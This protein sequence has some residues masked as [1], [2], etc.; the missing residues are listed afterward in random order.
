MGLLNWLFG[1]R[2]ATGS[3]SADARAKNVATAV[4][5]GTPILVPWMNIGKS[6]T[7]PKAYYDGCLSAKVF[8][9]QAHELAQKH[10][11]NPV[12]HAI[13]VGSFFSGQ[14]GNFTPDSWR[15]FYFDANAKKSVS[16]DASKDA[17]EYAGGGTVELESNP[18]PDWTV[19]SPDVIRLAEHSQLSI[20]T[21]D[22]LTSGGRLNLKTLQTDSGTKPVWET[23]FLC[24]DGRLNEIANA[25]VSAD[26]GQIY[27]WHSPTTAFKAEADEWRRK[28]KLSELATAKAAASEPHKSTKMSEPHKS[29]KMQSITDGIGIGNIAVGKST[30]RSVIEC[31]GDGFT[32]IDHN[33]YSLEMAFP[34][35]GL[36]FYYKYGDPRQVI[37]SIHIEAPFRGQTTKGV[38]LGEHTM[39]DVVR[40]YGPP[41][42]LTSESSKTWHCEYDGIEFHSERE[43]NVPLNADKQILKPIIQ[44]GINNHG[45]SFSGL[46]LLN[47]QER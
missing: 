33:Q 44:I 40:L 30:A 31:Y 46:D 3:L 19:D 32:L 18:I 41:I 29:T 24:I 1:T 13:Y 9:R 47:F 16:I 7:M 6:P 12:L 20:M 17:V 11:S 8:L 36:S 21:P 43:S 23:P 14:R 2:A 26:D 25:Y 27:V 42:W 22:A 38:V 28:K 35:S 39:R 45:P 34:R 37:F 4:A 5:E 15:F 10:T